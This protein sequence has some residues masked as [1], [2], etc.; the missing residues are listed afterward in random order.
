MNSQVNILCS[1]TLIFFLIILFCVWEC[2]Y[3][4]PNIFYL[5]LYYCFYLLPKFLILT[6][7]SL[8]SLTH[9]WKLLG[10]LI[11]VCGDVWSFQYSGK[12]KYSIKSNISSITYLQENFYN[13]WY[14]MFYK[15]SPHI[16][17]VLDMYRDCFILWLIINCTLCFLH[18]ILVC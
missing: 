7:F 8:N 18:V 2:P 17:H 14:F 11:E 16:K 3:M 12:S 4:S 9:G 1:F 13:C 10:W 5:L 15:C 6:M